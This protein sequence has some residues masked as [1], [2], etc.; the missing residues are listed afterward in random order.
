MQPVNDFHDVLQ[1]QLSLACDLADLDGYFSDAEPAEWDLQRAKNRRGWTQ[2]D[3]RFHCEMARNAHRDPLSLEWHFVS[4]NHP[5]TTRP[6]RRRVKTGF[7]Q[8]SSLKP[9]AVLE[10]SSSAVSYCNHRPHFAS[11]SGLIVE[12]TKAHLEWIEW[13]QNNEGSDVAQRLDSLW[14]EFKGCCKILSQV[15]VEGHS[16]HTS[17]KL[18]PK[19]AAAD[20]LERDDKTNEVVDPSIETGVSLS[21]LVRSIGIED[22]YNADFVARFSRSKKI[23][24]KSIGKCPID[25]RANLYRLFEIAKDYS[26]FSPISE[27][28]KQRIIRRLQAIQRKPK[29]SKQ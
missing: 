28:E 15:N 9:K 20:K 18:M 14:C 2:Q 19:S 17:E 5:N 22:E 8:L 29:S 13:I 10:A 26:D 21:D 4:R 3:L 7:R 6:C 23:T 11:L 25:G 1:K 16:A 12:I 24:A 27:A